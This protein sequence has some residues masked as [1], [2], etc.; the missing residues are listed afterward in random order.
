MLDR[1]G[2]DGYGIDDIE[3]DTRAIGTG[4]YLDQVLAPWNVGSYAPETSKTWEGPLAVVVSEVG[5]PTESCSQR[6]QR[7]YPFTVIASMVMVD[8]SYISTR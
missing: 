1:R 4:L 8:P 7:V 6:T 3:A 5:N 2:A